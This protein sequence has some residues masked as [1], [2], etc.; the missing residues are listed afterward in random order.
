M[1][2]SSGVCPEDS[3]E[4]GDLVI[5][6]SP[7][8]TPGLHKTPPV[9]Q[10]QVLP[11]FVNCMFWV[12]YVL[13]SCHIFLLVSDYNKDCIIH[14]TSHTPGCFATEFGVTVP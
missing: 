2:V 5:V 6:V 11:V 4:T 9:S 3:N 1:A 14:K 8:S 10:T 7:C 12:W 13:A